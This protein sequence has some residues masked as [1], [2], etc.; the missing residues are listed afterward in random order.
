MDDFLTKPV[1]LTAL[2][3]AL[4]RWLN[5]TANPPVSPVQQMDRSQFN[6]HL[7]DLIALLSDNKFDALECFN[8]L[9]NLPAA[10]ELVLALQDVAPLIS[11]LR[12]EEALLQL[13]PLSTQS[14]TQR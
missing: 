6:A 1:S 2:R 10:P 3:L 14:P 13:R 11:S 12:F 5:E 7:V 4:G 9:Q 8:E